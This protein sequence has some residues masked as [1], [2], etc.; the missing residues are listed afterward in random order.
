MWNKNAHI[1]HILYYTYNKF[2]ISH[3]TFVYFYI[4]LQ[5]LAAAGIMMWLRHMNNDQLTDHYVSELVA[6]VTQHVLGDRLV[7]VA[8]EQSTRCL[9]VEL[10]MFRL[11]RP[12]LTVL[13]LCTHTQCVHQHLSHVY[14]H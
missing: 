7:E 6:R 13:K 9:V 2:N 14:K 5:T 4:R 10:I 1:L 3:I 8:N 11:R 12:E